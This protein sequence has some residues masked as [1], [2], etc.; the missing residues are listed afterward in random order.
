M[1]EFITGYQWSPEN[2]KFMGEY[3]FPKNQDKKEIHMP[4]FTTLIRPPISENSDFVYW[5]GNDWYIDSN[6]ASVIDHPHIDDYFNL[7]P[8]YIEYLKQN[9]LWTDEDENK[10]QEAIE[11]YRIEKEEWEKNRDYLK[12]LRQIRDQLLATSDW[13]QLP[14][15]QLSEDQKEK[16]ID[17]RQKL[18]HLPENVENPKSLVLDSD[19][20]DWPIAP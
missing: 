10:R 6:P 7:I 20:P 1:Q 3:V 19:H 18:R 5:D 2:N 4:P 15:V 12:E 13:T 11:N 16:W 14:D 8:D 9:H 17:Y